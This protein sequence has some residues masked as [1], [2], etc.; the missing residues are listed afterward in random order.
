MGRQITA[1]SAAYLAG[2]GGQGGYGG[3]V[4]RGGPQ[5]RQD[6]ENEMLNRLFG[7][8]SESSGAA[9]ST[10]GGNEYD[11]LLTQ[12]GGGGGGGGDMEMLLRNLMERWRPTE[13]P[14]ELEHTK[15]Q[16]ANPEEYARRQYMAQQYAAPFAEGGAFQGRRAADVM[17]PE[18]ILAS[19][20]N[21]AANQWAQMGGVKNINPATL[22]DLNA[23][24]ARQRAGSYRSYV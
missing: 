17:S 6:V 2:G 20:G 16:L 18:Q 15:K 4:A 22:Q 19:Q 13:T 14:S 3:Y 21:T 1:R 11:Q 8:K 7:G 9:Y 23:K 5:Q 24:I 12:Y 10:G